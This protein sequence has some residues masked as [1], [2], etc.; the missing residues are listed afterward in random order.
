MVKNLYFDYSAMAILIIMLISLH[1]K[2]GLKGRTNRAFTYLVIVMTYATLYDICAVSLDNNNFSSAGFKYLMHGGYLILRNLVP[3]MYVCYLITL[4]NTWHFI[5][6]K[7]KLF[8]LTFLPIALVILLTIS[9]PFTK[10]IYYM[11]ENCNYTRGPLFIILYLSAIFYLVF[12][13]TY[14]IKYFK[15]LT[16]QKFIPIIIIIPLQVISTL[17]QF[18]YPTLLV[19]LM[20][21][22]ISLLFIMLTIQRP[23]AMIDPNTSLF[24]RGVYE[25]NLN[26]C[27]INGKE[28]KIVYILV[29]NFESLNSL[30]NYSNITLLLR[31][32]STGIRKIARDTELDDSELYYLN[33]G[34]FA[35]IINKADDNKVNLF[36]NAIKDL[37]AKEIIISDT[38]YSAPANICILNVPKDLD[39]IEEIEIFEEDLSSIKFSSDII[40]ASEIVKKKDYTVIA[41]MDSILDNAIKNKL[42]EVYYQP[43]YSLKEKRFNS[44]EALI[45]LKT[46]EYGFI[47]PDIFI[48]IAEENGTI[49][50]IDEIVLEEVCKFVSSDAFKALNLDYIEVNLSVV[51]CMQV[52]LASKVLS[53]L[54]KYNVN[55]S[56]INLEIT[57]TA[58]EYAQ[59]IINSNISDMSKAGI[60]FSLDDFGTGYSNMIR[61]ASLPLHIVKLDRTFT[62]TK[63]NPALLTI[64]ENTIEM[65]QNMGMKIVVE[66]VETKEMLDQFDSYNCDY[67]QGYYFSKPLPKEEFIQ[68]I[69]NNN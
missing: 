60:S 42:F 25:E 69:H 54:E 1:Y 4:T 31:R 52:D 55:P 59:N 10:L 12:G 21:S 65:I 27:C 9:S 34:R 50:E 46:E 64:L 66:G 19:E 36:V 15:Q 35:V 20:F 48:P 37:F 57:E 44:A 39:D 6:K 51:Q 11:D 62:N 14:S 63:G 13:L 40:D 22:A 18:L 5:E 24:R 49:N 29:T 45:R 26:L 30:L 33:N 7:A 38:P 32:V 56:Q 67:I 43:I 28:I 41:K 61:I 3:V 47:R 68:Y 58:A 23:E 17:L 53:I 2:R 16:L 8:T